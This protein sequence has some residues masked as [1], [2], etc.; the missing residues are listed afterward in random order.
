MKKDD[1]VKSL[2]DELIS[3]DAEGASA[4]ELDDALLEDVAGGLENKCLDY[5]CG[6]FACGTHTCT[7][8]GTEEGDPGVN[9]G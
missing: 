2:N 6:S 3:M 4:E 8:F 5:A 7:S 9:Q 1:E